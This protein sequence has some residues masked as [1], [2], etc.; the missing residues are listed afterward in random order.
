[1]QLTDEPNAVTTSVLINFVESCLFNVLQSDNQTVDEAIQTFD[2][3]EEV[4]S[5][6]SVHVTTIV[7]VVISLF[8]PGQSSCSGHGQC[9]NATCVCDAGDISCNV[10]GRQIS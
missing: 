10:H 5:V 8:C 4:E 7:D 3:S 2:S 1:M 6:F 9:L